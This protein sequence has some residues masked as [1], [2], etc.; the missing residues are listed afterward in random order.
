[1]K[2]VAT[3]LLLAAAAAHAAPP[4]DAIRPDAPEWPRNYRLHVE[5]SAPAGGAA[6][7]RPV[8]C[9]PA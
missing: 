1:M 6:P 9:T 2:S 4:R 7:A 8:T 5:F 3:I